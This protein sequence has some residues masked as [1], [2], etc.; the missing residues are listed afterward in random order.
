MSKYQISFLYRLHNIILLLIKASLSSFSVVTFAV[1]F[2]LIC[3]GFCV[4]VFATNLFFAN[5]QSTDEPIKCKQLLH[6]TC[7]L[8]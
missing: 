6:K 8:I 3:F 2:D 4:E 7:K 5:W 1:R